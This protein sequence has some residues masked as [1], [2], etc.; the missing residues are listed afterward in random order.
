[1]KS[2]W[3]RVTGVITVLLWSQR[4]PLSYTRSLLSWIRC[5][6][7][8]PLAPTH[9]WAEWPALWSWWL[10]C[11]WQPWWEKSC[12]WTKPP[13]AWA[14]F[15]W[16]APA[17][18]WSS[19][20]HTNHTLTNSAVV[21]RY[22]L[23]K[24]IHCR[25]LFLFKQLCVIWKK[26]VNHQ[27]KAKKKKRYELIL[28]NRYN[29]G[30]ANSTWLKW[31][32]MTELK[33]KHTIKARH[34]YRTLVWSEWWAW[35]PVRRWWSGSDRRWTLLKASSAAAVWVTV[36]WGTG[37]GSEWVRPLVSSVKEVWL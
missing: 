24:Q 19:P 31:N 33:H 20:L 11:Y 13:K 2:E 30:I 17:E 23:S 4:R 15:C 9:L 35:L 14:G 29:T 1:M 18:W 7:F 8:D 37:P 25:A 12:C 22:S 27:Q 3:Q 16:A 28:W 32:K 10:R 26:M 34:G 6:V 21:S 5:G 36:V